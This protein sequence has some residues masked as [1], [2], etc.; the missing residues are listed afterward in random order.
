[1][2]SKGFLQRHPSPEKNGEPIEAS[3]AS[4]SLDARPIVPAEYDGWTSILRHPSAWLRQLHE[5]YLLAAWSAAIPGRREQ[6]LHVLYNDD[7][8]E[9][10]KNRALLAT[11]HR[12]A[13]FRARVPENNPEYSRGYD[14][15]ESHSSHIHADNRKLRGEKDALWSAKFGKRRQLRGG[16]KRE[17]TDEY[18]PEKREEPEY[19]P[20]TERLAIDTEQFIQSF[21]GN[22]GNP[23]SLNATAIARDR[24]LQAPPGAPAFVD[25]GA[26]TVAPKSEA[27]LEKRPN[28]TFGTPGPPT[29]ADPQKNLKPYPDSPDHPKFKTWAMFVGAGLGGFCFIYCCCRCYRKRKRRKRL[30]KLREQK[31]R[32]RKKRLAEDRLRQLRAAEDAAIAAQREQER[33]ASLATGE[34]E[35]EEEWDEEEEEY[36]EEEYY[37]GGKK[38]RGR[39]KAKA[40]PRSSSKKAAPKAKAK[41]M[42]RNMSKRTVQHH[43]DMKQLQGGNNKLGASVY[44]SPAERKAEKK[45]KKAGRWEEYQAEQAAKL[46]GSA[47][48]QLGASVYQSASQRKAAKKAQKGGSKKKNKSIKLM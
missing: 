10:D 47:N 20:E 5:K 35:D 24:M 28:I 19:F 3:A 31:E 42:Q 1:M 21:Q 37:A 14:S 8:T 39:A 17:E 48:N 7:V 16:E 44:K 23:R 9:E 46:S 12:V 27:E 2:T 36:E 25:K 4:D 11:D 22:Q 41:G 30:K 33:L 6:E 13:R 26:P 38:K 32:E 43:I 34:D 40:R 45:A 29:T 15:K 18:F